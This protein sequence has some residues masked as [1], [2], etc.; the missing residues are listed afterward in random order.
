MEDERASA[1]EAGEVPAPGAP[2]LRLVSSGSLEA[3]PF[4]QGSL[5]APEKATRALRTLGRLAALRFF[6]PPST[7]AK[8]LRLADPIGTA[9]RDGTLRFEAFSACC[10]VYGRVDL[11][12]PALFATA[13]EPGTTQ[14]D[15]S[16]ALRAH[17]GASQSSKP[18]ELTLEERGL[19]LR[20]GEESHHQPTIALPERWVRSLAEVT[21]ILYGARPQASYPGAV[22]L[23]FLR[24]LSAT[25]TRSHQSLSFPKPGPRV[26]GAKGAGMPV[27]SLE[28]LRFLRDLA[29][30]A[31]TIEAWFEPSSGSWVL[32]FPD[33]EVRSL[34]AFSP[35]RHRGFSGEGGLVSRL[36]EEAPLALIQA[37]SRSLAWQ[38][39][40]QAS[41]F[42]ELSSSPEHFASALAKL[43]RQ[44]I[45]GYDPFEESFFHRPI[46]IPRAGSKREKRLEKARALVAAGAVRPGATGAEFL[47]QGERGCYQVRGVGP[48]DFACTCPFSA[49]S[50]GQTGPCSHA[51]AVQLWK[52]DRGD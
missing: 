19:S 41:D 48:E 30:R 3:P 10:S 4:F 42:P 31:A 23:R 38:D 27:H 36:A 25:A 14:V 45:L 40:V 24:S 22:W 13:L 28:R 32:L 12:P 50:K 9:S 49:R 16:P 43:S 2:R 11:R 33:S 21:S 6:L 46:R 52:K 35:A 20:R 5:L 37:L 7:K 1:R 8:I 15:F 26:G 18:L 47:V 39:R 34:F 17:F 44:G 29:A 51:L